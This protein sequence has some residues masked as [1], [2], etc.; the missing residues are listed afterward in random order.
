MYAKFCYYFFKYIWKVIEKTLLLKKRKL[1][2]QF[3]SEIQIGKVASRLRSIYKQ[4]STDSRTSNFVFPGSCWISFLI[5]LHSQQHKSHWK[6]I[7]QASD[8]YKKGVESS[9]S[10]IEYAGSKRCPKKFILSA[11]FDHSS[12]QIFLILFLIIAVFQQG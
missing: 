10:E 4:H 3:V 2:C 11:N 7:V 9:C 1:D 12:N 8:Y 6:R 5:C